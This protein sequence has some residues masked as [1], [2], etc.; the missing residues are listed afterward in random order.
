MEDL[1]EVSAEPYDARD[2]VVCFDASPDPPVSAVRQP[3]PP[4]PGRLARD[5]DE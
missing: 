2:P 3:L 5:D 1:L 4:A